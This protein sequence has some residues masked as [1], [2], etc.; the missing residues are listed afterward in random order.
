MGTK[1]IS[2]EDSAYSKLK[3]AKRAGESFSDIIHRILGSREPSLLEFTK[4]LDRKASEEL[5][6]TIARMREE[7]VAL[8]RRK[9]TQAR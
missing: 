1:T 6:R 5:V 7:D 3:A 8:Q 2:L 4:L 9:M